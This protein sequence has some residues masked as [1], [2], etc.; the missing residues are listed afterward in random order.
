VTNVGNPLRMKKPTEDADIKGP[1]HRRRTFFADVASRYAERFGS[2]S[3][4]RGMR[5]ERRDLSLRTNGTIDP[6]YGC[7]L[8]DEMVDYAVNYTWPWSE[9]ST[10][11]LGLLMC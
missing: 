5:V 10:S 3:A 8:Y 9:C 11:K 2:T 4:R 7:E 1:H 6:W